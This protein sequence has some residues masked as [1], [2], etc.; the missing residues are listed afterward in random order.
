MNEVDFSFLDQPTNVD[1]KGNAIVE[2]PIVFWDDNTTDPRLARFS[3]SS[4]LLLHSC[5]RK[6][7]LTKLQAQLETE[8]ELNMNFLFGHCLG[9]G[10]AHYLHNGR[11]LQAT[12]FQMYLDWPADYLLE[13]A[14]QKKSFA[15]AMAAMIQFDAMCQAG[16]LEDY[17][18]AIYDGKPAIELSFKIVLPDG[19]TYRGFVDIVLK[20][21]ITGEIIVLELKTDSGNFVNHYKYKNSAQA[22]GYSVVLDKI[23]PE[24]SAYSVYYLVYMT[25]LERFEPFDFPKTYNQRALW[26]RDMIYDLESIQR[27]VE[28]EGNNGI[29]PQHGESCSSWGRPCE[30]M[31]I[32]HLDT[33]NVITKLREKDLV[34]EKEY[35]FVYQFEELL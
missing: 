16:Y 5:P 21:K 4:R 26:L 35:Q 22:I 29:W 18:V 3:Y 7:Q 33:A 25:R 23:A 17:E 14:K 13:N 28:A 9:D 20:H 30:F 31:D 12:I 15:Y 32:C 19:F 27:Y 8:E 6:Y 1:S 34:E 10:V 2:S 24:L 11:N